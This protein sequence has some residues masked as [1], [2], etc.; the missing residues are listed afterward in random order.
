MTD[1][2]RDIP[3]LV[4]GG[5]E[6]E[7]CLARRLLELGARLSMA[8]FPRDVLPPG[9]TGPVTLREAAGRVRA[10]VCPLSGTDAE[11][12]IRVRMDAHVTL[13]LDG[14]SLA[15]CLPGT[16]LLIGTARPVVRELVRRLRL[17]LVELNQDEEMALLNSVPT[18]EGAL[19][20]AMANLRITI[21]QSRALVVGLGRCGQQITRILVAMGASVK[22]VVFNRVEGARAYILGV[23]AVHPDEIGAAAAEVDVVFNTAPAMMLS[24]PVLARMEPS[25]LIIDIAS[26]PGGT[27]FE[28]AKLK[29]LRAIHAVGLPGRVAPRT[30]GRIL[31]SVVPDLLARM[32]SAS[33]GDPGAGG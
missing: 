2:L 31:A 1:A 9:A 11:G 10:I 6:R 22:A 28:A 24:E 32:L 8:G 16:L 17:V 18:A 7:L 29:G 27:D 12:N 25:T 33:G 4:A 3:L 23:D 30:A 19:Q 5:D 13:R 15:G 21:H 20:L 14:A 26:D